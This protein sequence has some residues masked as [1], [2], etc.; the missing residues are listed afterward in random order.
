MSEPESLLDSSYMKQLVTEHQFASWYLNS[1][2]ILES[3]LKP[4]NA[5][6]FDNPSITELDKNAYFEFLCINEWVKFKKI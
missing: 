2:S 4:E 1:S 5:S 6:F 3:K